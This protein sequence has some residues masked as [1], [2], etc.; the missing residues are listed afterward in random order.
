MS[1]SDLFGFFGLDFAI[2]DPGEA[3]KPSRRVR[4]YS[5]IQGPFEKGEFSPSP[6]A[7]Q[8]C[9]MERKERKEGRK[10]NLSTLA[11]AAFS[12]PSFLP[13]SP[14][15]FPVPSSFPAATFIFH[16]FHPFPAKQKRRPLFRENFPHLS[17]R[18]RAARWRPIFSLSRSMSRFRLFP[19][20]VMSSGSG[21]N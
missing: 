8:G 7:R 21:T 17:A 2:V 11:A 4:R 1:S 15:L 20:R 9:K 13:V 10:A 16:C 14:S 3:R 6:P 19:G 18:R 5:A 12:L